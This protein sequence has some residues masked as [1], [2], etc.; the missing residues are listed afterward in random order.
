MR[1]SNVHHETAI[2]SLLLIQEIE[3]KT[4]EKVTKRIDGANT[5]KHLKEDAFHCPK[6]LPTM[7]TSW[8][9]YAQHLIDNLVQDQK[10]RD[11][12]NE[13]VKEDGDKFNG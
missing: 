4:W 5:I 7:F 10:N 2:R 9:E 12:L 3:P 11:R 1:I 6:E 8:K 13:I